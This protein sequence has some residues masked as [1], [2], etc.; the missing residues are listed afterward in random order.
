MVMKA[1][2]SR[3][4]AA[5]RTTIGLM[6]APV[7]ISAAQR[8]EQTSDF[9]WSERIDAGRTVRVS[10]ISGVVTVRAGSGD[11]VEVTAVKRWRRGDPASVKVYTARESGDIR[12][13][14]L[15]NDQ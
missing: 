12:I 2:K 5:V 15:Y 7:A 4:L 14:P 9:R 8:P 11:R 3:S 10:N 6:I 1:A 13:C